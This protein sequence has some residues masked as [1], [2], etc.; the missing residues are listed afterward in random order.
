[1]TPT[2]A[3][4]AYFRPKCEAVTPK[5]VMLSDGHGMDT[6]LES[7][8]SEDIYPAIFVLRPAYKGTVQDGA[9]LIAVFEVIFFVF[10]LDG[11]NA[12][13]S[14]EAKVMDIVKDLVHD[15]RTYQ[16]YFDFNTFRAEPVTYLTI[17]NTKAYEVKLKLGLISNHLFC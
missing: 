10:E 8:R 4:W 17:D 15:S 9:A 16:C 13:A 12:Y 3:F 5:T 14:A 7:S 2:D 6:L 11:E 1:M